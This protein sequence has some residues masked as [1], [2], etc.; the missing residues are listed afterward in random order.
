MSKSRR[1]EAPMISALKQLEAG[2]KAEDMAREYGVSKHTIYVWKALD[3]V[4]DAIAVGRAVRVLSV[5]ARR[6]I[7][8][9]RRDYN[10]QRPHSSLNYRTPA[11]FARETSYGKDAGS[12]H[13]ERHGRFPLF[14]SFFYCGYKITVR[15]MEAGQVKAEVVRP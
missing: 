4:H 5:V 15:K 3:F 6:K 9:W 12:A 14:H 11:E 10:K 7:A 8:F 13:L 2:R 1:T